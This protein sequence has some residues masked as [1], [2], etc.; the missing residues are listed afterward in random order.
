MSLAKSSSTKRLSVLIASPD[1]YFRGMVVEILSGYGYTGVWTA[2]TL[3]SLFD[4]LGRLDID[5][6]IMDENMPVL[7]SVEICRM[8]RSRNADGKIPKIVLVASKATRT[9]VDEARN[10]GFD[11]L[12]TKPVIPARLAK[13]LEHLY[14]VAMAS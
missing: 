6:V 5:L 4:S 13:T 10:A 11:A 14:Q 3:R 1:R 7:S 12:I 9:L 8:I 2:E